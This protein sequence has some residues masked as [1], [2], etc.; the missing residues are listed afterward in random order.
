MANIEDDDEGDDKEQDTEE[1]EPPKRKMIA[2]LKVRHLLNTVSSVVVRQH[3]HQ[4][5]GPRGTWFLLLALID[6]WLIDLIG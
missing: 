4:R 3:W 1:T 6:L 5:K 2:T